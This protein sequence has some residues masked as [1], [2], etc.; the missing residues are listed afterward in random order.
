MPE[1]EE[2]TTTLDPGEIH[3]VASTDGRTFLVDAFTAPQ[4][5][6]TADQHVPEAVDTHYAGTLD[7]HLREYRD[8][9]IAI[10]EPDP[11]VGS[12]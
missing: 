2:P 10:L 12:A 6:R 4:A 7:Q 8:A 3:V 5:Q 11:E 9:E 1:E